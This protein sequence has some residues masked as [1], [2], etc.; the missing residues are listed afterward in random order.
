[1]S[2]RRHAK[3][4]ASPLSMVLKRAVRIVSEMVPKTPLRTRFS[5]LVTQ[6]SIAVFPSKDGRRN[7]FFRWG[8]VVGGGE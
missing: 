3:A 8:E 1:M 6:T 7:M 5:T 2:S 4:R